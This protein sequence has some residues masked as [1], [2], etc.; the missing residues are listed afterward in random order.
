MFPHLAL[1]KTFRRKMFGWKTLQIIICFPERHAMQSKQIEI[2][3]LEQQTLFLKIACII[4]IC[5]ASSAKPLYDTVSLSKRHLNQGN[6]FNTRAEI[7]FMHLLANAYYQELS[8]QTFAHLLPLCEN[9]ISN[10]KEVR[11]CFFNF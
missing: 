1:G 5:A 11:L 7:N 8:K 2:A 10:Y 3:I 6:D 4:S 9:R